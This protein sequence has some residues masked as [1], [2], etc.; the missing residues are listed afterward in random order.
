MGNLV[1]PDEWGVAHGFKSIVK[2]LAGSR[3]GDGIS[4]RILMLEI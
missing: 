2:D 3:H 1:K 4:S